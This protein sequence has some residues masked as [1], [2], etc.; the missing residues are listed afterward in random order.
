MWENGSLN[1]E[2]LT[3]MNFCHFGGGS[4]VIVVAFFLSPLTEIDTEIFMDEIRY[5]VWDL[6]R[7]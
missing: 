7:N 2:W 6:F 4:N 3:L 1:T 5:D